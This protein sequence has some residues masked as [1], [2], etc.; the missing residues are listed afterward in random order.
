MNPLPI[1]GPALLVPLAALGLIFG[2]FTTA[3]SYR[4]PRGQSIAH[5][6]SR[7]PAC[8]HTLAARDLVPVVSWVMHKGGCRHCGT[9]ISWRYPAIELLTMALFVAAGVIVHDGLQ[10]ALLLAMT[11]VCVALA[12]TDLEHQRL[13]NS[14]ILVLAALALAWRAAADPDAVAAIVTAG[15]GVFTLVVL[16]WVMSRTGQRGVGAGDIKLIGL[17]GVALAPGP[18]LL[19]VT[20]TGIL[21]IVSGLLWRRKSANGF[22]FAPAILGAYW[23]CLVSGIS[24][25]DRIITLRLG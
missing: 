12:V 24:L 19:F 5:G 13:P 2:S 21:G 14:L 20:L 1:D 23:L 3:L 9:R 4:L 6:R 7:C 17:A 8:G 18:F 10:L 15:G 22:P 16:N 25:L 11:P